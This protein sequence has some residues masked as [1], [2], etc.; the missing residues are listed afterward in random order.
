MAQHPVQLNIGN[1]Q[2]KGSKRQTK[3]SGQGK[4]MVLGVFATADVC[5]LSSSHLPVQSQAEL[6]SLSLFIFDVTARRQ[7]AISFY[8]KGHIEAI[9]L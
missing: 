9:F 5:L 1:A 7:G 2:G 8:L 3:Q 6:C 4:A